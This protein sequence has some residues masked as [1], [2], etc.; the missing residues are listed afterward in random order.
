MGIDHTEGLVLAPQGQE[1]LHQQGVLEHVREITGVEGVA[2][3]E[4]GS[5][6]Y[7]GWWNSNG[8]AASG[9]QVDIGWTSGVSRMPIYRKVPGQLSFHGGYQRIGHLSMAQCR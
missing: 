5:D 4:H 7:D 6:K 8:L 9:H 3:A 2:V 1:E